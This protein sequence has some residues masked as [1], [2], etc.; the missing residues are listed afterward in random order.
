VVALDDDQRGEH[1]G[2][3]RDR[4]PAVRIALPEHLARVDV[5]EDPGPRVA[6]ELDVHGRV[7]RGGPEGETRASPLPSR[8]LLT[9][10]RLG[11]AYGLGPGRRRRLRGIPGAMG[12]GLV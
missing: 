1:L 12:G 5:E 6:G 7:G 3:A 11:G 8:P 9:F 10:P 2:Q 4:Q